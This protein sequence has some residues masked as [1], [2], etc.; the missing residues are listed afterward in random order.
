VKAT[1]SE[2]L[3]QFF[4]KRSGCLTSALIYRRAYYHDQV[5]RTV[6]VVLFYDQGQSTHLKRA[7]TLC[8]RLYLWRAKAWQIT[9][10]DSPAFRITLRSVNPEVEAESD[11]LESQGIATSIDNEHR[12][13]TPV[14]NAYIKAAWVPDAQLIDISHV[15][16]RFYDKMCRHFAALAQGSTNDTLLPILRCSEF[17]IKSADSKLVDLIH[18]VIDTLPLP[19]TNTPWEAIVD[20][21]NDE[22][23]QIKFRRLRSWLTSMATMPPSQVVERASTMVDDYRTYMS[24]HHKRFSASR[25]EIILCT[26]ADVAEGL[27]RL[28]FSTAMRQLF[29]LKHARE[30]LLMA[31]LQAPGREVAYI[32]SATDTLQRR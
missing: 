6:G 16:E 8:D 3:R 22:D 5:T 19:T 9:P 12:F 25:L 2:G 30:E 21:R 29:A 10:L 4:Q 13:I 11:W 7:A 23:A 20:F 24:I 31:E 28:K 17:D 26:A 14:M 18:A 15:D 1:N 32:A 27:A